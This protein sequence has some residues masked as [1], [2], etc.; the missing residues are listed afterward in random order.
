MRKKLLSLLLALCVALT[1]STVPATAA[2]DTLETVNE[3]RAVRVEVDGLEYLVGFARTRNNKIDYIYDG[4]WAYDTYADENPDSEAWYNFVFGGD[5]L[6]I[7]ALA[8]YKPHEGAEGEW[9]TAGDKIGIKV[10]GMTLTNIEGSAFSFSRYGIVT[11]SDGVDTSLFWRNGHPGEAKVEAEIEITANGQTTQETVCLALIARDPNE[12][13]FAFYTSADCAEDSRIPRD[14][15]ICY[16]TLPTPGKVWLKVEDGFEDKENIIVDYMDQLTWQGNIAEITI[17]EP[18]EPTGYGLN[19][20]YDHFNYNVRVEKIT[21]S[22]CVSF[23][24]ENGE[25]CIGFVEKGG[26]VGDGWF[27]SEIIPVAPDGRL[28][29][30]MQLKV[31]AS[32]ID[33]EGGEF[34][35]DDVTVDVIGMNIKTLYGRSD[36]FSF[37]EQNVRLTTTES[38]PT[39]YYREGAAA[40]ALITAD[41]TITAPFGTWTSTVSFSACLETYGLQLYTSEDLSEE[42]YVEYDKYTTELNYYNLPEP[43]LWLYSS[44][45]LLPGDLS[46]TIRSLSGDGKEGT[47]NWTILEDGHTARIDLKEPESVRG[48]SLNVVDNGTGESISV[49][50]SDQPSGN[51]LYVNLGGAEYAAGFIFGKRGLPVISE[52]EVERIL[53]SLSQ[54]TNPESPERG[55]FVLFDNVQVGVARKQHDANGAVYYTFENCPVDVRVDSLKIRYLD[56]AEMD[57]GIENNKHTFSL[58]QES[59]VTSMDNAGGS[60]VRIFYRQGNTA[61]AV[62][63]A[64]VTLMVNGVEIRTGT[65]GVPMNVNPPYEATDGKVLSYTRPE[66]DT[67]EALNA[68]MQAIV[69]ALPDDKEELGK[70]SDIEFILTADSYQG[71]I[72]IPNALPNIRL[73]G[74]GSNG[75][76]TLIG[77]VDTN[78][79]KTFVNYID[80]IAQESDAETRAV[81]GSGKTV[82]TNCTFRGYDVALDMSQYIAPSSCVF[83]DNGVA[84]RIDLSAIYGISSGTGL[85][86]DNAFVNNDT[87]VQVLSL[88]QDLSP[89]YFRISNCN[90]VNNR[91]TFDVRTP[92]TFY[93]YR[94]FYGIAPGDTSNEIVEALKSQWLN[95]IFPDILT[96]IPVVRAS[97][98]ARVIT[99]PRW[100]FR[101]ECGYL[102]SLSGV[103]SGSSPSGAVMA[104]AAEP[105]AEENY[106]TADWSLPTEI[107]VG[108]E[109]LEISAAAFAGAA[110]EDRVISVV[111]IDESGNRI[112]LATW[113]F[114]KEAHPELVDSREVFDASVNVTREDGSVEVEVAASSELLAVLEPRLTVPDA[115]GSVTHEANGVPSGNSGSSVSFTVSDGGEY[116]ISEANEVIPET[117][118]VPSLPGTPVKP[119]VTPEPS[120]PE[121]G[122]NFTDVVSGAWYCDAVSYVAENELMEGT[123]ATTF[124]PNANMTRAMFWTILARIDGET[125]SGTDWAADARAWAMANGVSDGTNTNGYVTREQLATMLWRYADEP[126]SNYS[127]AD[128]TDADSVSGYAAAAMAWAVETG[129]IT[130]V[131][132]TTIDP[133]G[134][135]TRAQA[136]AM[137]MRFMENVK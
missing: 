88:N 12:I 34:A 20:H 49:Q 8:Y 1:L 11:E 70:I 130:G 5:Y 75:R 108:E 97:N 33:G 59:E 56:E 113:N 128:F 39:L 52:G 111:E 74:S 87:A 98:G 91:V 28:V 121:S 13:P 116:V 38:E 35:P 21:R 43:V 62:L 125:I 81:Y 137:L 117:P 76:T 68:D 96:S 129:I 126:A 47:L 82:A 103:R 80:F 119:P 120:E 92:G 7:G 31:A 25:C 66:D 27:L 132:S 48:Y 105:A 102:P 19:V 18:E 30:W 89:Y 101:V 127:F 54:T 61:R 67:V 124:E 65:V 64:T 9:I 41:I 45:P 94:N 77:G 107:V 136:A 69:D 84:L 131:T 15:R 79:S 4:G 46:V 51:A 42:S 60:N 17:P 86:A 53:Y 118:S 2:E 109:N 112:E 50:I 40:G 23:D 93:F 36:A 134:T 57:E 24:H 78:G 14:S 3:C 63:K 55:Q 16:Y 73:Y 85:F 100:Y 10:N 44:T 106:L 99:N 6:S 83:A 123:S 90:F 104:L 26:S 71:T 115:S 72:E 95:P 58:S 29:E 22:S 133:Q 122:S 32:I 135:A 37:S 110:E 114:G